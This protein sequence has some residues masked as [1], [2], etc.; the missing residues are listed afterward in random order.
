MST[1][2]IGSKSFLCQR[3]LQSPCCRHVV[4]I[5]VSQVTSGNQLEEERHMFCMC[6]AQR[7]GRFCAVEV[8][9]LAGM[10]DL[11]AKEY[12]KDHSLLLSSFSWMGN[13]IHFTFTFCQKQ[14]PGHHILSTAFFS[15][16]NR[17]KTFFPLVYHH[18]TLARASASTGHHPKSV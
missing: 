3:W 5:P 9:T 13:G 12:W 16:R 8:S 1:N 4:S 7:L 14:N 11:V 2:Y 15:L 6:L 10:A 18:Y 17:S